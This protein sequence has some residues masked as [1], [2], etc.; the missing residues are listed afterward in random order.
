[1]ELIKISIDEY[2]FELPKKFIFLL[3]ET[4]NLSNVFEAK[5]KYKGKK[6]AILSH[7]TVTEEEEP[8]EEV[9]EEDIND[10]EE[11]T[12]EIE[13]TDYVS[14]TINDNEIFT[15]SHTD[16]WETL[17]E[18]KIIGSKNNKLT[19][20]MLVL[21][22]LNTKILKRQNSLEIA[23]F[24][25]NIIFDLTEQKSILKDF[26]ANKLPCITITAELSSLLAFCSSV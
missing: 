16:F 12:E 26:L 21:D 23:T 6:Y 24:A 2:V 4:H 25:A 9:A 22:D 17:C 10:E 18:L 20:F 15:V 19:N 13:L 5:Y 8:V 11:V 1:M 7:V 14:L 3:I